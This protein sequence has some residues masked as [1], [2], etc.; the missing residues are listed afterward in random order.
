MQLHLTRAHRRTLFGGHRYS[1]TALLDC[2]ALERAIIAAHDFSRDRLYV[3]PIAAELHARA[4]AARDRQRGLSVWN[5]EH[6]RTI[7]W[8]NLKSIALNIRSMTAFKVTVDQLISAGVSITADN[9]PDLLDAER[10]IVNAFESLDRL[11]AHAHSFDAGSET[12]ISPADQ[13]TAEPLTAPADWPRFN[14]G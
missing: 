6:Q 11:V 5:E 9:L 8:E 1:I 7:I 10:A 2:S 3:A 12:L 13:D 4:E 14:N